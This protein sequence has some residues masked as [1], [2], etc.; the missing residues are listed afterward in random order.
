MLWQYCVVDG[1][2]DAS[3]QWNWTLAFTCCHPRWLGG[4]LFLKDSR[5]PIYMTSCNHLV[6]T[7]QK[8]PSTKHNYYGLNMLNIDNLADLVSIHQLTITYGFKLGF[9]RISHQTHGLMG[10]SPKTPWKLSNYSILSVVVDFYWVSHAKNPYKTHQQTPDG[11]W[12]HYFHAA[13]APSSPHLRRQFFETS[14]EKAAMG[15]TWGS[16]MII[17][18]MI[19]N[20]MAI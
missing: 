1:H 8:L 20:L 18:D 15:I 4:L 5:V 6:E 12:L 13:K 2:W 11:W 16:N 10:S 14:G 9:N 7:Q 17:Y 19:S 3:N